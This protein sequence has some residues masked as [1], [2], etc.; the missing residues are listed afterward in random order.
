MSAAEMIQAKASINDRQLLTLYIDGQLFGLPVHCIKDIFKATRITTVP[1]TG[2]EV[3]GV[4]NLRGRIVTA[5]DLPYIISGKKANHEGPKMNIAV[6]WQ[7]ETYSF[8]V[9]SVS[10][11]MTFKGNTF[12]QNPSTLSEK[13]SSLSEGIFKLDRDLLVVLNIEKV[14]ALCDRA[15]EERQQ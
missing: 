12:E 9:D 2:E 14:F 3:G 8:M 13:L 6:E 11:V 1:L 5:L 7:G 4:V 15:R 10:E